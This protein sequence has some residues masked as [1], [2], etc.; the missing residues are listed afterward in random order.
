MA[1][2]KKTARKPKS[3]GSS[4]KTPKKAKS[5]ATKKGI[6][7]FVGTTKGAF[8]LDS[9]PA[10]KTF[11]V[12]K[13]HFLGCN[14]HHGVAD[15]RDPKVLL[16]AV[17]T[18]HLGPTIYR[19]LN[20]GRTWIEAQKPPALS[21]VGRAK[22]RTVHHT[23][24]L[25]P[26]HAD[27]PGVWYA[28]TSPQ[29]LFRSEDQGDTWE[30]VLGFNHH[31]KLKAWTGNFGMG[32]PEG[33][34]LHS[35]LIHPEDKNHM[36]VSMSSGGTFETLDQGETWHPLNKGVDIDF[37]PEGEYEFGHDP[38]QV[39]LHPANPDRLY[40]QNHCGIYRL[41]RPGDTWVRIGKKMPKSVGDIGFPIVG[42]PKNPDV[43]WVIPMDGTDVWP[44]ISPRGKPAV[45][46]TEN[47]GKTWT[48]LDKGLPEA[49]A[50]LTVLRQ[51]FVRDDES[52]L[53]L[54]FG[55]TSGEIWASTD[56]GRTWKQVA[57]HLPRIQSLEVI[58]Q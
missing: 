16:L 31:K 8:F 30:E 15:P 58:P 6:R 54:Y 57:A 39:I 47:A 29:G 28:G 25:T 32:T 46:Q 40:Q 45:H 7:L 33:A 10:R 1:T 51:C 42:D 41:D 3:T 4:K 26:G 44:R 24:W 34:K 18:G 49:H 55:T 38:H 23:F 12:S 53:G 27:E 52:K 5:K 11:E 14:I 50:Y 56:A 17:R 48:R 19:S 36:Y 20:R 43:V 9:D 37:L 35:I 22:Q 2:K 13:P 21:R